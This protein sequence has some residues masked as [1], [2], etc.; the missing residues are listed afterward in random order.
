[1]YFPCS[2]LNVRNTYRFSE[3]RRS[4]NEDNGEREDDSFFE[5][6]DLIGNSYGN[7]RS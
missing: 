7:I 3:V 6:G 2:Q 1:M 5:E 4:T